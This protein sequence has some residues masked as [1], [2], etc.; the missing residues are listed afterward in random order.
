MYQI[1]QTSQDLFF[2]I[3]AGLPDSDFP[4]YSAT[5]QNNNL[6]EICI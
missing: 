2:T 3:S 4:D 1:S 6:Y 5:F